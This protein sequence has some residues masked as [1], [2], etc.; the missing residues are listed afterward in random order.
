MSVW[1]VVNGKGRREPGKKKISGRRRDEGIYIFTIL[2]PD[3][4]RL[5]FLPVKLNTGGRGIRLIRDPQVSMDRNFI[6]LNSPFSPQIINNRL[7]KSVATRPVINEYNTNAIYFV[8]IFF[9]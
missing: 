8:I 2:T 9:F 3:R 5:F 7:D 1:H 4:I 6:N